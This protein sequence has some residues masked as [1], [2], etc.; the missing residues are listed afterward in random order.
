MPSAS[1]TGVSAHGRSRHRC[2]SVSRRAEAATRITRPRIAPFSVQLHASAPPAPVRRHSA[3]G[4]WRSNI[5]RSVSMLRPKRSSAAGRH[6]HASVVPVFT[7][8]TQCDAVSAPALRARHPAQIR[9]KTAQQLFDPGAASS[10]TLPDRSKSTR[11]RQRCSPP[12]TTIARRGRASRWKAWSEVMPQIGDLQCP[13]LRARPPMSISRCA[14]SQRFVAN[15]DVMRIKRLRR[16]PSIDL[17]ACV[18]QHLGINAVQPPVTRSCCGSV[19]QSNRAPSRPAETTC[20]VEIGT[21]CAA[22]E[23][24]FRECTRH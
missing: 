23:K 3:G 2:A 18:L 5:T 13:A 21:R 12:P 16:G 15:R 24:S 9:I 20:I 14:S 17:D 8:S 1:A 6:P 19:V 10:F 7:P 4:P 11:T 22:Y